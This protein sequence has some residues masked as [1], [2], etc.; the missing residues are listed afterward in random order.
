[1]SR[2]KDDF[3]LAPSGR[4]KIEWVKKFLIIL[5]SIWEKMSVFWICIVELE[6]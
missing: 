3:S 2:I 1:M 5:E 4:L 6:L